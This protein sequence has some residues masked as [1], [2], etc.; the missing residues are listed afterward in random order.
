MRDIKSTLLSTDWR[1]AMKQIKEITIYTI[2]L[3]ALMAFGWT[4][5]VVGLGIMGVL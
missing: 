2:L 3:A 1:R 5:C 4:I